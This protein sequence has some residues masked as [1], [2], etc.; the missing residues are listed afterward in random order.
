M[1]CGYGRDTEPESLCQGVQSRHL[2]RAVSQAQDDTERVTARWAPAT[3]GRTRGC[4]RAWDPAP[5]G[6]NDRQ[7]ELR[8][9]DM[10]G[11]PTSVRPVALNPLS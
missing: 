4:S 3:R 7:Q 6:D 2:V 10:A 11:A 9:G 8:V 1:G 5:E